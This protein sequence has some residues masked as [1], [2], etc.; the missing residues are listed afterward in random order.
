NGLVDLS[1]NIAGLLTHPDVKHGDTVK[2]YKAPFSQYF[3]FETDFRYY[4]KVGL[5]ST[6]ASRF[7]FGYGYPYGNSTQL[8]YIKQ[9]FVGGTK[10]TG[11]FL[12]Q[13]AVDVGVG[14]RLDITVFV[15]RLDLGFPV[16]KPWEQNPWVMRQINFGNQSWRRENLVY[17]IGIGYPF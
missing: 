14:L 16:R 15:I 13:L 17:N 8:P 4:R 11:K 9:F 2:I 3:K 10:F 7:D 5:K 1:G 6:W 12:N